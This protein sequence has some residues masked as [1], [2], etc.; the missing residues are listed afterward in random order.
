MTNINITKISVF[1]F[2][3]TLIDTPL[4]KYGI[5]KWEYFYN[6]SYP[7]I[8]KSWWGEK[9]SLD[10]D[11]FKDDIKP[12]NN[13]VFDYRVNRMDENNRVILLTHRL[14]KLSKYVEDILIS[15]DI[16]MDDYLY[17]ESFFKTKADILE[18]Y[19]STLP[20]LK[21]IE[22]WEDNMDTINIY[23]NWFDKIEP[24]VQFELKINF[25]K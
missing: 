5:P 12:I 2:D 4:P 15:N 18:K 16:I 1:D 19:I 13:T 3:G 22:I 8:N 10:R 14:P 9:E 21:T 17:R 23:E 25:I 7:H 24:W 6:K 20:N 11:V